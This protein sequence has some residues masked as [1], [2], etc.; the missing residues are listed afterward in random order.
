MLPTR[1]EQEK[2]VSAAT[3]DADEAWDTARNSFTLLMSKG[4]MQTMVLII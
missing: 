3:A 4:Y 1:R 2:S